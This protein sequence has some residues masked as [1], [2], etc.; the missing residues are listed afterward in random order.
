MTSARNDSDRDP[1]FQPT[2]KAP[3]FYVYIILLFITSALPRSRV[4]AILIYIPHRHEKEK[5]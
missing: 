3:V 2:T 1:A 4:V 5:H